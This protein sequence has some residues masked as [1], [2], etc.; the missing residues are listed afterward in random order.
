MQI[1]GN[2]STLLQPINYLYTQQYAKKMNVVDLYEQDFANQLMD[3]I[4][5]INQ[6]GALE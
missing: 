1:A 2:R 6:Q 4:Y 5:R 3:M